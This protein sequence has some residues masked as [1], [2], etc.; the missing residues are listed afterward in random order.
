[1]GHFVSHRGVEP[2]ASKVATIQQWPVP[3]TTK[4]VR[5]L[6]GLAGFYRRFIQK[7]VTIA[8]PLVKA[9]TKEPL[10]W[11]SE[12]QE[13]FDTLKHALSIAPVLALLDF[14]LPFTVKTDA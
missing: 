13:A 7:Y 5:S 6:L 9:M 10:Q 4:A 2:L 12:T 1:M 8:A 3:R 14:D 11:T